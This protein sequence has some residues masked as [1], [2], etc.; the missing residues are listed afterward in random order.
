MV[1][2][3]GI[4][5]DIAGAPHRL[6]QFHFHTPSEHVVAG[7]HMAM[8]AHL[9]HKNLQTGGLA[10]L[11]V[12]IE[13]AE[14]LAPNSAIAEAMRS[15]PAAPGAETPLQRPISLRSLLP[16][17]RTSDGMRPYVNY[18]WGWRWALGSGLCWKRRID[19]G[20]YTSAL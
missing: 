8:E 6:I 3:P 10:V 2:P 7:R 17:P 20:S 18:R 9:V 14:G 15:A 12:L 16:N 1:I 19:A 11:G 4:D 5:Y 13:G